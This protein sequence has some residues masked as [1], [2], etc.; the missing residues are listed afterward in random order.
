M[1]PFTVRWKMK[2]MSGI[3]HQRRFERVPGTSALPLIPDVLLSRSKR[4]LGPISDASPLCV[5]KRAVP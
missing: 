4:R 3:G 2:A 1:M 5:K